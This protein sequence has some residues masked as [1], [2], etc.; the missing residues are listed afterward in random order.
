MADPRN[1][2]E[3]GDYRHAGEPWFADALKDD[4]CN[5]LPMQNDF[6]NIL[7]YGILVSSLKHA[8]WR[9]FLDLAV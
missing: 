1:L 5:Q 6:S 9:N 3:L 8:V 2:S 7:E 4:P